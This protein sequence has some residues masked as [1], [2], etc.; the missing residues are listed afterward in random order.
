MMMTRFAEARRSG[1][2]KTDH[3]RIRQTKEKSRHARS[4]SPENREKREKL[5]IMGRHFF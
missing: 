3:R 1:R 5:Y 4:C 2:V